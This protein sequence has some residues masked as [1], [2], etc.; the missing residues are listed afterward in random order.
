MD[1][2]DRLSGDERYRIR[3]FLTR[4]EHEQGYRVMNHPVYYYKT[5]D[6]LAG[7]V[8]GLRIKNLLF[9]SYNAL[10]EDQGLVDFSLANKLKLR[11]APIN[12]TSGSGRAH[13]R[14]V[15]I[16]D[17]LNRE[18]IQIDF[19]HVK[20]E[21]DRKV[22]LVTGAAG[23]IGSELCRQLC[24]TDFDTLVL[25][26]FAETPMYRI[27]L[28]LRNSYPDKQ[29]IP[30]MGDVRNVAV[31][32]RVMRY[33][34]PQVIFH[35]AAYKH[36]PMMENFPCE[37]VCDNLMGT[38]NVADM[39]VKYNA[40]KFVMIS[41]DKAVH[42]SSVMGATKLLSERYVQSLGRAIK[43][44]T[45]QGRTTFVTTRFGNVLGSNGSVVPLFRQQI[46]AGGPV[47]VTHPDVIRYF[48]TIPEACRLVLEAASMGEGGDVFVFDM[49]EPVK[50][51]DMARR[52][53]RLSGYIPDKE[54]EVKYV[55]L[56]PGEKLYEELLYTKED[57]IPT[58]NSK[59][60]RAKTM[61]LDFAEVEEQTNRLVSIAE[62]GK[63][64]ETVD[65]MKAVMPDYHSQNSVYADDDAERDEFTATENYP[66]KGQEPETENDNKNK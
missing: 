41:T 33:F 55:G 45:K 48:M 28:E 6:D 57:V 36:V 20:Q 44:G 22:V 30:W 54:I 8:G 56:R 16:D 17:L 21:F 34:H 27:D 18:E 53:I 66:A 50:I 42:P 59:I 31:L 11:I 49:G 25:F 64:R 19:E 13:V 10:Q 15:A 23:S 43:S 51:A 24:R 39:A 35:A 1:L 38:R 14:E 60:F 32:E 7:L 26:D 12:E 47:T 61:Q 62:S 46:A 40:E 63:K 4:K 3:G 5:V 29:I 37:A 52:M 65:A 58:Q 2:V 9:T